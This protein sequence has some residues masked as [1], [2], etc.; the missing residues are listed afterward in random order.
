M[1]T[2]YSGLVGLSIISLD[3]SPYVFFILEKIKTYTRANIKQLGYV[4]VLVQS[5]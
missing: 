5:S 4:V 3:T 2:L 1:L